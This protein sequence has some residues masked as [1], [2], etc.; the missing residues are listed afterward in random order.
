LMVLT[1]RW[2]II[3]SVRKFWPKRLRALCAI[4]SQFPPA[5]C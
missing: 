3:G 5:I 2:I 4:S 1:I